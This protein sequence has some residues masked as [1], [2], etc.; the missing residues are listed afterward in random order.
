M[1]SLDGEGW[2]RRIKIWQM[3]YFDPLILTFSRKE[4]GQGLK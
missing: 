4:K 2:V 1:P 3:L